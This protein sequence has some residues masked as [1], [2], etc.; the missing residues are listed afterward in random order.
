MLTPL[1]GSSDT[2]EACAVIQRKGN[3]EDISG[4]DS[5]QMLKEGH[6]PQFP[7][8]NHGSFGKTCG[9][10]LLLLLFISSFLSKYQILR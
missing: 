5:W 8:S 10:K 1:D 7:M 3:V 2:N 9:V 6:G 4:V